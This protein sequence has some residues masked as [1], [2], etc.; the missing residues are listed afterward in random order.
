MNKQKAQKERQKK[1]ERSLC[2]YQGRRNRRARGAQGPGPPFLPWIGKIGN[3]QSSL[4][5]LQQMSF[6]NNASC[7]KYLH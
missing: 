2:I 1:K 7:D 4:Q 5:A 6:Y 3:V